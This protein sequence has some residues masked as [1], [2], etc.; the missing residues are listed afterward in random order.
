MGVNSPYTLQDLYNTKSKY[1]DEIG[2][3]TCW[4]PLEEDF[5]LLL[6]SKSYQTMGGGSFIFPVPLICL[7]IN[8]IHA[9]MMLPLALIIDQAAV[10]VLEDNDP[11]HQYL[12]NVTVVTGIRRGSGTTATV[13]LTLMGKEGQSEPHVLHDSFSPILDRGSTDS[14]LLTTAKG[15]GDIQALRLWHN[16]A[17]SSP[18]W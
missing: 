5:V 7:N 13:T 16:N 11:Y 3:I 9:I 12:Y 17:G 6:I 10:T 2:V 1:K 14:F 18:N 4:S 8:E 15:L